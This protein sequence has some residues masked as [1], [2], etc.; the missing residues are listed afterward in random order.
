MPAASKSGSVRDGQLDAE[1][2]IVL[3][4]KLSVCTLFLGR[5]YLSEQFQP[6]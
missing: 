5:G 6:P 3:L 1:H 4:L 2:W